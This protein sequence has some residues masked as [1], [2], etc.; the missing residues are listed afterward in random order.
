MGGYT[1]V[2]LIVGS[3]WFF[4]PIGMANMAP[5]LFRS[6]AKRLAIPIDGGRLFLGKPL[7]GSHK[8]WRG[9]LFGTLTGGLFFL[10]QVGVY[11]VFPSVRAIAV[12]DYLNVPIWTGL[13]LGFGAIFGDLIK[14]FLKRRISVKPG[15]RWFPFDQ[16]DYLLGGLLAMSIVYPLTWS[17]W[18]MVLLGGLIL[19]MIV[20]NI[21]FALGMKETRW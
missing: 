16:I 9:L 2:Q 18:V 11:A 7:F 14:S 8:T 5:V 20:N 19:H 1:W 17:V 6:L 4:F 12:F 3:L 10:M 15:E 21:G 13:L